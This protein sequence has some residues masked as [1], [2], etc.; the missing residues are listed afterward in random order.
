LIHTRVGVVVEERLALAASPY[1][2]VLAEKAHIF[3]KRARMCK[4]P[5]P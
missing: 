1:E 4:N 3:K 2:G 5:K